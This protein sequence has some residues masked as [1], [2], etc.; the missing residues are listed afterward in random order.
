MKNV[1]ERV[2]NLLAYLLTVSHP[3]TAEEIRFT[4]AG[5][6]QETDEA[7][8][9]TFE[10]DKE[11]LRRLGIPLISA[12][13]DTWSVEHGYLIR[14]EDYR[15]PDPHLSD[16]ER[17]ALWLAAQVVRLGGRPTGPEAVLK[18]GGARTTSGLEPFAADL[19]SEVDALADLYTAAAERQLVSFEYRRRPRHVEP[20][21]LGHRRGH[22]YL[23]AVEDGE[24]RVFRVDR[25]EGVR[26]G[27]RPGA[28]E[29][30]PEVDVRGELDTHP[31]EV[32]SDAPIPVTV[33]IDA[34]LAWWAVRRMGAA[35]I[36]QTQLDDGSL[37]IV[38]EVNHHDA[39]VGW[40]LG[41]GDRA[42]VIDPPEMRS[43]V[44]DRI[45]GLA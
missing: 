43:R 25:I 6:D 37:R 24:P 3:V 9:R 1:I 17:A 27:G 44:I 32:G 15:M 13:T 28:F 11:L 19:G 30:R 2:L 23:V 21:G 34:E 22:W 45:R 29:R 31:W 16:E 18:L 33:I 8:R 12:P 38:L 4:V 42:E 39:F 10:R 7:F 26:L 36:E 41:F 35:P 5:Y 40:I 20:Y 14:P